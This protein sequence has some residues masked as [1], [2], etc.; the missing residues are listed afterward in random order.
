MGVCPAGRWGEITC[1]PRG[2]RRSRQLTEFQGSR[3]QALE[4]SQAHPLLPVD[5]SR[6]IPVL[7]RVA[8]GPVQNDSARSR[9]GRRRACRLHGPCRPL[10][11]VVGNGQWL[12]NKGSFLKRVGPRAAMAG[13]R[14]LCVPTSTAIVTVGADGLSFGKDEYFLTRCWAPVLRDRLDSQGYPGISRGYI[15]VCDKAA[16]RLPSRVS[17]PRVEGS[18]S[19]RTKTRQ[20]T[21]AC[22]LAAATRAWYAGHV[23]VPAVE[24]DALHGVGV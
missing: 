7:R 15:S 20:P 24:V 22:E 9:L 13:T 16:L 23:R 3:R 14:I 6:C 21:T 19:C 12:G 18:N 5:A 10:R 8:G 2:G 4:I 17:S 1:S 11:K